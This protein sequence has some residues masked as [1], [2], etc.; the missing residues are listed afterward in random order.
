MNLTGFGPLDLVIIQS[1]PFCNL[2]CDY[3]YLPNRQQQRQF[4]LDLIEP[5]LTSIFNSPFYQQDFTI[6]W[7]AGEPLAVPIEFYETAFTLI[8]ELNQKLNPKN[9]RI[10][11][12]FQTNG[13]LIQQ[14][15]CDLFKRY[16]V[17]VGVSIDGPAFIHDRHRRNRKGLGSHAATMRGI[18]LLQKNNLNFQTISVIT[19]ESLDYPEAMYTFFQ[20]NNICDLAFNIEEIEGINQTSSLAK[21][22]LETKYR[23]FLTRFW[24][25]IANNGNSIKLRE[26]EH[27]CHLVYTGER[28]S[29]RGLLQ[30]FTIISID[31]EGNFATFDPEL[32][33]MPTKE[34]GD[35]ILGNIKKDTFTSVCQ[36][37][38]FQRIY[39]D[40]N[41]GLDMCKS[42]CE[43][44]GL[45]G[46]GAASNK[47]WEK[48]TFRCAETMACRYYEKIT[49]QVVME[50]LEDALGLD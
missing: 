26:F 40:I 15:W 28:V 37:E 13:T 31:T 22:E 32:L 45:C 43:Y 14:K 33:S 20:E 49:T 19:K 17:H 41:A 4:S 10:K 3:C 9:Y 35:F 25:L 38:K 36:S 42:S 7:H 1:T 8:E 30:P 16:N 18:S 47:Y 24:E 11:Q 23:Q 39:A 34:Y 44:F 50:K 46:G 2:D 48:G 6:C 12:S 21:Q 5:I 27:I 29:R